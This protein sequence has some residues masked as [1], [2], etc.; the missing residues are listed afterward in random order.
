MKK[1]GFLKNIMQWGLLILFF[2][3]IVYIGRWQ[4]RRDC[5]RQ[6][7]IQAESATKAIQKMHNQIKEKDIEIKQLKE[8]Q[9]WGGC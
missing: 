7:K 5:V 1:K 2:F 8:K 4:G 9:W 3:T 6:A